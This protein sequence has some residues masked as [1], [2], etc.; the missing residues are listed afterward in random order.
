MLRATGRVVC[1][2]LVGTLVAVAALAI[3]IS[4]LWWRGT[5]AALLLGEAGARVV[6]CALARLLV[7][8]DPAVLSA[9]PLGVPWRRDWRG[10][11]RRLWWGV[12]GVVVLLRRVA[13]L[14][15]I[16]TLLWRIT[17]LLRIATLLWGV[18]ALLLL[19][20]LAARAAALE[21]RY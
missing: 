6:G 5:V 2:L 14:L 19:L 12:S 9:I 7:H 11:G 21:F 15:G 17:A 8:K 3:A 1:A 13:A 16:A 10:L 4:A 18:S 20:L